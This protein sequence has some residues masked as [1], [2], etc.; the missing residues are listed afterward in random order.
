MKLHC[1]ITFCDIGQ[2]PYLVALAKNLKMQGM[3]T[4][5]QKRCVKSSILEHFMYFPGRRG[6]VKTYETAL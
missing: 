3:H 6:G 5:E 1:K 4:S 2:F